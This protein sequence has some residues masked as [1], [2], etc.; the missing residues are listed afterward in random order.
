[1]F[2]H[3]R[4]ALLLL[5]RLQDLWKSYNTRNW[6]IERESPDVGYLVVGDGGALF[7]RDQL[8]PNLVLL[9]HGLENLQTTRVNN[10][11]QNINQCQLAK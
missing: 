4:G 9:L 10:T 1:M 3:A 7:A 8:V 5:Q 2:A 6:L 11:E